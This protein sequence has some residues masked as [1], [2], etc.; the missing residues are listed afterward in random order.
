M[1]GTRQGLLQA[2]HTQQSHSRA[3][4]GRRASMHG[5]L[6][7]TGWHTRIAAAVFA[8]TLAACA[9]TAPDL[10]TDAKSHQTKGEYSAA[11]VALNEVLKQRPDD[12]E[13]HFL[14]GLSYTDA[15][16]LR[17][18]E[19]ELRKATELGVDGE[20]VLPVLARVLLGKQKYQLLV[21]EIIPGNGLTADTLAE[22]ALL[23]GRARLGLGALADARTEFHLAMPRRPNEAALAMAQL[24]AA[25]NDLAT[26]E[27][28]V[29][30]VLASEPSSTE[31]W[32]V[33]GDLLRLRSKT[34]DALAAYEFALQQQPRN[35]TALLSLASVQ[36][37]RRDFDAARKAINQAKS[38]APA[39][40]KV[41]FALATMALHDG[42]YHECRDHL[43]QVLQVIP[44]HMP[45]ILLSGA[46]F[47]ATGQYEQAQQA[48]LTFLRRSPGNVYARKLLASTLLKKALPE[49]AAYVLEPILAQESRDSELLALAGQAYMQSGQSAKARKLLEQAVALE[50]G[51][52]NFR[53]GLGIARW[54][55]G[56]DQRAVEDL[57]SAALLGSATSAPDV[58]LISLLIAQNNSD[59]ALQV[60]LALEKKRPDDPDTY[61]MK[62][63]VFLAR[64]DSDNARANFE[65]AAQMSKSRYPSVGALAQMDLRANNARAA[66][67]RLEAFLRGNPEHFDAMLALARINLAYG[68]HDEGIAFLKRLLEAHPEAVEGYLLMA[69]AQLLVGRSQE[70]INAAQKARQFAPDDPRAFD[71]LGKAQL[72]AGDAA[73]AV[74]NFTNLAASTP[75]SVPTLLQLATA[76]N[77]KRDYRVAGETVRQALKIDPRN[78][79]AQT[80]LGVVYLS[81]RRFQDALSVGMRLQKDNPEL[82]QGYAL[83]GDALM[84]QGQYIAAA[85]A[86][87]L[88][89]KIAASGLL[90]VKLHQA[91]SRAA[92]HMASEELLLAWL[93]QHPD[94]IATRLYLA[95]AY[96]DAGRR[97]EGLAQYKSLLRRD[98]NNGNALNNL[99]WMLSEDGSTDALDYAQRAFQVQP[100]SGVA[101]DT[102]GWILLRQGKLA[103]G[104]SALEKAAALA[105]HVP[106]VR[107]HFAQAL[108]QSGDKPRARRELQ[109]A[110]NSATE[111]KEADEARAMLKALPQ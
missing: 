103:D 21:N 15:G 18:A 86:F 28:L 82:P 9:K 3:N 10:M 91:Q 11:I 48:V 25:E 61:H 96:V 89:D 26:A 94:D 45:S 93:G 50:P 66:R 67:A 73:S 75:R 76:Y 40:L 42:N 98:P 24:A 78:T 53:T 52:P 16:E 34:D 4:A 51:N 110:L 27:K 33:K 31:G 39:E 90:R 36:L 37:H 60:A 1:A 80:T 109:A 56:D 111:F 14:I 20:R 77:A 30:Q 29:E 105:P 81:E 49:N 44:E 55:A 59:R 46:M 71:V 83:A 23:R 68:S 5:Q 63:A 70:A 97:T 35:V 22:L 85:K 101:A 32:L 108:A 43:H 74:T 54:A 99:A 17:L 92:K 88:A 100:N 58:Y 12:A 107:Y 104:M 64:Q 8:C 2:G 7:D 87:E 62:G 72:A 57:Q 47:L 102:L 95:D 106:Q 65:R 38:I 6:T 79:D 19:P 69:Q 13:A 41:H 84:A